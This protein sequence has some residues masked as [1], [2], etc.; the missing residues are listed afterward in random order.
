MTAE[1]IWDV[2]V[3][4]GSRARCVIGKIYLIFKKLYLLFG[5]MDFIIDQYTLARGE[6]LLLK[7]YCMCGCELVTYQ[8]DGPGPLLRCYLDRIRKGDCG[9]D[10]LACS[11]CNA[12]AGWLGTYL[13]EKRLAYFL[14]D[15]SC[16]IQ[17]CFPKSL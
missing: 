9:G 14:E 15:G 5:G 12:V 7:V 16:Q 17:E 11:N 1:I 4:Q 13:K 3:F 10:R 6:P 8:K 2:T